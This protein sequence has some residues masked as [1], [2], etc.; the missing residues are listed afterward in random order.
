M[1]N[2]FVTIIATALLYMLPELLRNINA[3]DYRMLIYA[4]LLISV[5]LIKNST[6]AKLFMENAKIKL[7]GI[8]RKDKNGEV[9]SNG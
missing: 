5:M 6:K 4:I 2:M 9:S 3:G 1:G 7:N 8:F